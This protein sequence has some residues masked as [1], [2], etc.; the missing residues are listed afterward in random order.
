MSISFDVNKAFDKAMD[1]YRSKKAEIHQ[2]DGYPYITIPDDPSG[3]NIKYCAI[4]FGYEGKLI[5]LFDGE[6]CLIC[7]KR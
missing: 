1:L 4:C 5:P 2:D 6:T 3:K 7:H